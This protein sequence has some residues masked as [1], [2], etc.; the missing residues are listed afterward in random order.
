MSIEIRTAYLIV[1]SSGLKTLIINAII[2]IAVASIN[3]DVQSRSTVSPYSSIYITILEIAV[4]IKRIV[5]TPIKVRTPLITGLSV[6]LSLRITSH[7][8]STIITRFINAMASV[9]KNPRLAYSEK[10]NS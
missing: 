4:A 3:A 2:T 1:L 6:P 5:N 8:E 10:L 7:T 9:S